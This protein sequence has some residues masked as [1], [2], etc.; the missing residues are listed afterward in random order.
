MRDVIAVGDNGILLLDSSGRVE[1]EIS[2]DGF[3]CT[4]NSVAATSDL[5][6]VATSDKAKIAFISES[7]NYRVSVPELITTITFSRCGD[8]LYGGSNTGRLYVWQIRTGTLVKNKQI[9]F[10]TITDAK[11]DFENT[12]ILLAAQNGDLVLI[13]LVELFL[14]DSKGVMYMGHSATIKG[15]ANL[16]QGPYQRVFSFV[17]VSRDKNIRF[18]HH[19]KRTAVQSHLIEHEPLALVPSIT[20]SRLYL[21]CDMG[22]IAVVPYGNFTDM[23]YL[24][25]HV[26]A[27]TGC[28]E[29]DNLVTCALDG[30]RIWDVD[31]R[32]CI[33]HYSGIGEHNGVIVP[34]L[35][36]TQN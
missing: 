22:Y 27:V 2:K 35:Y 11:V 28:V 12:T 6:C 16:M 29:A 9:F 7:Q 4:P 5:V 32:L 31:A 20:A 15:I 25:G 14:E 33:S 36:R 26:G 17:S 13:R 1:R 10:N 8:V 30:I 3:K 19:T 24:S 23:F 21:P 18:W 34:C